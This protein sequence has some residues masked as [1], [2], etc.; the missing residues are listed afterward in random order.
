[1]ESRWP[2]KRPR[3]A[4]IAIWTGLLGLGGWGEVL[5][6]RAQRAWPLS[7]FFPFPPSVQTGTQL[8]AFSLGVQKCAEGRLE[9]ELGQPPRSFPPAPP[10]Q[11]QFLT[12]DP[13][14]SLSPLELLVNGVDLPF[15]A[16]LPLPYAPVRPDMANVGD[17]GSQSLY[18]ML[19]DELLF[20]APSLLS[21]GL[22]RP[23]LLV[24]L[25]HR[26]GKWFC[27]TS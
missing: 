26:R 14:I 15:G 10:N 17:S 27:L 4:G 25:Q 18:V 2:Q 12:Y 9:T 21:Q 20:P 7:S 19:G 8:C 5:A 24:S 1:M 3:G 11:G 23:G 22:F 16:H 13:Q 6:A